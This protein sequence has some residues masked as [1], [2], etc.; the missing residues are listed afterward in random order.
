MALTAAGNRRPA[1]RSSDTARDVGG[2]LDRRQAATRPALRD[3]PN[4]LPVVKVRLSTGG[5]TVE[6]PVS[7]DANAAV[8]HLDFPAEETSIEARLLDRAGG[9]IT[10][11]FHVSIRPAPDSAELSHCTP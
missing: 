6:C 5:R 11:A 10:G 8:M 1:R 2:C 7:P 4:A 9:P 3:K